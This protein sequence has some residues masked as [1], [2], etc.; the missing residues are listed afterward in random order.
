MVPII[1]IQP[2]LYVLLGNMN[3]QKEEIVHLCITIMLIILYHEKEN[4]DVYMR[5]ISMLVNLVK[6]HTP[7]VNGLDK[8]RIVLKTTVL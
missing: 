5:F 6:I 3:M 1:L 7:H 8:E 4:V 2:V